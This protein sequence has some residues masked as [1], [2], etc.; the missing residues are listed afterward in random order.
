MGI[1]YTTMMNLSLHD[2]NVL[3]ESYIS[4]CDKETNDLLYQ[5]HQQALYTAI[6]VL[7]SKK[8]PDKPKHVDS[9]SRIKKESTT[10]QRNESLHDIGRLLMKHAVV[11]ADHQ[12]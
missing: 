5:I 11:R 3:N 10:E 4:K 9:L 12:S 2:I 7:D 8:F 6:A 1:D